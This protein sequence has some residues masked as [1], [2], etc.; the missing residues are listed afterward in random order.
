[1]VKTITITEDAYNLLKKRKRQ[2]QS[3]SKAIREILNKEEGN[4][5]EKYFGALSHR[6]KEI[7]KMK[8]EIKKGRISTDKKTRIK[9]NK[10]KKRIYDS[11]R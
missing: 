4:Q 2:G 11:S 8:K 5:I 9:E 6:E 7:E 10:L 1:M 3:F